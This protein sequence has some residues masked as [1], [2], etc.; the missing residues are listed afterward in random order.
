MLT[1]RLRGAI[2]AW[3]WA[4]LTRAE[5]RSS[6]GTEEKR[7]KRAEQKGITS[8]PRVSAKSPIPQNDK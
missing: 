7:E 8:A 2:L 4:R 1:S 5:G 3:I 6:K